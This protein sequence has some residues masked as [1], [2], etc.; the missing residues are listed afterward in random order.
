ME[1]ETKACQGLVSV[2]RENRSS[3]RFGR[4]RRAAIKIKA[5]AEVTAAAE[6]GRERHGNLLYR[7]HMYGARFGHGISLLL[8]A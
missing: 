3:R 1:I 7:E 2:W 6:A 4:P 8:V 5:P